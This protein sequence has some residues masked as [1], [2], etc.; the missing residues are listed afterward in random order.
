MTRNPNNSYC[1][2]HIRPLTAT[3]NTG[4]K[5]IGWE[6]DASGSTSPVTVT[7]NKDLTVTAKFQLESGDGTVNLLKD[8]NFPSSSV[9]STGDDSSW[10]LGQGQYWG[11]SQASSSVSNGTAAINVTT[12]GSEPYQ[13]QLVQYGLALD[14]GVMYKLT[15]K[16]RASAA[17]KIQV[18]FQMATDPYT[19][20]AEKEFDLTRPIRN[21]SLCSL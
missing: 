13:P 11:D 20:Y 5:F 16:A 10:K 8:G 18:S 19:T 15:F 12:N 3:A 9:I 4:Y 17:R 21:T 2:R 6:G 14:E 1:Q 7:M